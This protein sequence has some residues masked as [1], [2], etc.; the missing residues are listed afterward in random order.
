MQKLGGE[1]LTNL[2]ARQFRGLADSA[3]VR[4]STILSTGFVDNRVLPDGAR[5]TPAFDFGM[6]ASIYLRP[7]MRA[8]TLR[9]F[10]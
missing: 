5:F 3:G 2:T 8:A 7:I 10:F 9:A 1:K 6:K 4:S